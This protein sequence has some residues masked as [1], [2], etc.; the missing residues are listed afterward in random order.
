MRPQTQ[1]TVIVE[2]ESWSVVNSLDKFQPNHTS[3]ALKGFVKIDGGK[4]ITANYSDTTPVRGAFLQKLDFNGNLLKTKPIFKV[5]GPD[6]ANC[7]GAML[8]GFEISDSSYIFALSSI[9]QTL[10]TDYSDTGIEGINKEERDIYI[11]TTDKNGNNLNT[12]CL[13]YYSGANKSA[14]VP[15]LTPLEDGRFMVLWQKFI[16]NENQSDT[17]CYAFLDRNG[18]LIG[19]VKQA[20]GYLSDSCQ[21][22]EIDGMVTWYVNTASGRTFYKV[23]AD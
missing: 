1:L 12:Q 3:H 15:Y 2:K 17:F 14:S 18:K 16:G 20:D 7:T 13:T 11:V 8:G 6:T 21:P 4:I 9:D 10:P 5:S 19:E 22:V 23:S